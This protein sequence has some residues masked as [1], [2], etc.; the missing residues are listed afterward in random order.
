MN[1]NDYRF[2]LLKSSK[3]AI[4]PACGKRSMVQYIDNKENKLLPSQYGRCDHESKCGYYLNPY[5]DGYSKQIW[6]DENQF[7]GQTTRPTYRPHTQ[8]EPKKSEIY[9]MPEEI[10]YKTED[11]YNLNTFIQNLY[12]NIP[13][14]FEIDDIAKVIQI[15]HLGTISQGIR[16]GAITFPFIDSNEK[17]RTIQVKNFDDTNH[18]TATD[19]LHSMLERHYTSEAKP[20]PEWLKKYKENEKYVSCLFGEH[21]LNM[22]PTNKIALVEAPKTAIYG[23]MYFGHPQNKENFIWLA[24]YN[25]SSFSLDKVKALKGRSIAVFPD[26]SKDGSTFKEWS[27]K[28]MK[29]EKELP[30]TRFVV[31]DLM[32]KIATDTDRQKGLDIADI[33][34]SKDWRNFRS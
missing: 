17:I 31:S 32:E 16:K 24:V 21:L 33:L 9:F 11:N 27:E 25:K 15:Y 12:K 4:C 23:T 13:Y 1:S 28:S 22:F 5:H 10:L 3:K 19:F 7:V 18:T 34:I 30:G 14:P 6:D 29:Y 2:V 26:L 8:P 20:L